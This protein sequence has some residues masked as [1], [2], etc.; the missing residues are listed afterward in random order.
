VPCWAAAAR[1]DLLACPHAFFLLLPSCTRQVLVALAYIHANG[2]IHR[3]V[4]AGNI[5]IDA[6]GHV[7]LGDFGVAGVCVSL[8][9]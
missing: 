8:N 7:K 9:E 4:K 1:P 2:N 5:L 3:D 6:E